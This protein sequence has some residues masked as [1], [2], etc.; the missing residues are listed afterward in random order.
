MPETSAQNTASANFPTLSSVDVGGWMYLNLNNLG[1]NSSGANVATGYSVTRNNAG[2]LSSITVAPT[3]LTPPGTSTVRPSQNWVIIEMFGNV[4]SNR[5]TVDFDA[6]WL[7]NGCSANPGVGRSA[8]G[9]SGAV[10]GPAGGVLVCP[11]PLVPGGA[12]CSP[13]ASFQG[14]NTTP[15][16]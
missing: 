15:L 4:G 16:P 9:S 2:V 6:A 11:P 13:S 14:M 12:G 5:L 10:I 8:D 3:G 1:Q 7:G